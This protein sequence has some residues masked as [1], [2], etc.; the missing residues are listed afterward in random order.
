[1]I[2]DRAGL[3]ATLLAGAALLLAACGSSGGGGTAAVPTTPATAATPTTAPEPAGADPAGTAPGASASGPDVLITDPGRVG[4]VTLGVGG[5][6][7]LELAPD[8][9]AHHPDGSPV[10]WPSPTSTDPAVLAP[11]PVGPAASGPTASGP[12]PPATTCVAFV[13]RRAGRARVQAVAPS[14]IICSSGRCVGV[15]APDYLIPV[16]VGPSAAPAAVTLR[17]L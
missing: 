14:G 17:H 11:A 2:R 3:R 12:C 5:R 1:M 6:I 7:R 9:T 8:R 10:T 13:A 15:S 16:T 4:D